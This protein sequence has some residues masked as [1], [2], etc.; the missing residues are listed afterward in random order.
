[1]VTSSVRFSLV[2]GVKLSANFCQFVVTAQFVV[3]REAQGEALC[4]NLRMAVAD[5]DPLSQIPAA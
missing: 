4:L 2:A 5:C 1:M 3:A